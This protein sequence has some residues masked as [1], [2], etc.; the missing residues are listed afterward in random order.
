MEGRAI[1]PTPMWRPG[2]SVK[3]YTDSLRKPLEEDRFMEPSAAL[4]FLVR[5]YS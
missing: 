3:K 4:D 1:D 5:S 2:P